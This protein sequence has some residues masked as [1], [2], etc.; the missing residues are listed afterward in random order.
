MDT[1]DGLDGEGI[2]LDGVCWQA[3]RDGSV[4]PALQMALAQG[5]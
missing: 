1:F 5:V 2:R 4:V 3:L